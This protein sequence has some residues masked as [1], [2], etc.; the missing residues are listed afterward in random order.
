MFAGIAAYGRKFELPVEAITMTLDTTRNEET[1]LI[2]KL[3]FQVTFPEGFPPQHQASILKNMNACYVK[4]HLF[5][6]PEVT[7]TIVE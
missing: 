1:R 4:K 5:D 3:D 2:N 7:V 6:P